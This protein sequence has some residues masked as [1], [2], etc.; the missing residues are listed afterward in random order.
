MI[1]R[2]ANATVSREIKRA[3]QFF[4]YAVD[5]EIISKNP[6]NSLKAG[7]QTNSKRKIFVE[8]S[9]I[10]AVI[11]ACPDNEWRLIVAF[12]RYGGLRIPSE[13]THL[14]WD[15]VDWDK[16]KITIRDQKNSRIDGHEERIIPI[17]EELRPFLEQAFNDAPEG[18]LHIISERRRS[19][20]A[21]LR[22]GLIR[23]LRKAGIKKWEKLFHNL[24]A[25][26]QTEL[27]QEEPEYKV[28]AW[29]GNSPQV[30]R[31]HYLM[32]TDDDYARAAG[33]ASTKDIS[34]AVQNP[35]Q[36]GVITRHHGPS[37]EKQFPLSPANSRDSD[38][39]IPPR[40]VEPR[41]SD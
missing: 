29:I 13:L 23:I 17:F 8:R 28:C 20:A 18:C 36:P 26:R 16:H 15:R 5:C 9:I 39:K 2:Y 25:S 21:N 37:T 30:A 7:Q 41:F 3:K 6:F 12:A 22:T 34:A 11:E 35:V 24:R 33:A 4:A 40:G 31:D 32:I 27:M 19:K 10:D 14:T 1:K 38:V